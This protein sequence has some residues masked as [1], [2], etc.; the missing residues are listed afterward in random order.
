MDTRPQ[1]QIPHPRRYTPSPRSDQLPPTTV[2]K[3]SLDGTRWASYLSDSSHE[4]HPTTTSNA[5]AADSNHKMIPAPD[6]SR[7]IS[8]VQ[9]T[10]LV[11][12][13]GAERRLGRWLNIKGEGVVN[14]SLVL[15]FHP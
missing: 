13:L 9:S 2:P 8:G 11:S 6:R 15:M 4:P 5:N 3:G 10:L 7:N 12:G 14:S 1:S